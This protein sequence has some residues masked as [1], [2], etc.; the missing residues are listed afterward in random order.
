MTEAQK[1]VPQTTKNDQRIK[2]ARE[3]SMNTWGEKTRVIG[4]WSKLAKYTYISLNKS[5]KPYKEMD[6]LIGC[7]W[8][9]GRAKVQVQF[10]EMAYA[11]IH[12]HSIQ[13]DATS[14]PRNLEHTG[15]FAD[16]KLLHDL[17][18]SMEVVDRN[19]QCKAIPILLFLWTL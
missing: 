4:D 16:L 6:E 14:T 8:Q 3:R 15:G 11:W 1:T 10:R 13:P 9:I 18:T 19:D 5:D 12:D 2:M 7:I 17:Y